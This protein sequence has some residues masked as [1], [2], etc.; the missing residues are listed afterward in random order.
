ML[1]PFGFRRVAPAAALLLAVSWSGAGAQGRPARDSVVV[2]PGPQFR[3][4]PFNKA[5]ILE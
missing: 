4:G 2:T 5:G 3:A 1:M